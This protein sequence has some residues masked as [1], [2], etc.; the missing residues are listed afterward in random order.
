MAAPDALYFPSGHTDDVEFVDPGA[1]LYPA[2]QPPLHADD[3]SFDT[4]PYFPPGQ[5]VHDAAPDA[6]YVPAEHFTAV[7]IAD[8]DGQL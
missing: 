2:T 8:P 7:A 6:L 4:D 1:Q 3:V 5:S